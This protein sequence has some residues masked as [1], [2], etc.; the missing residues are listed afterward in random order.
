MHSCIYIC[1]FIHLSLCISTFNIHLH[2]YMPCLKHVHTHICMC[3]CVHT[4]THT[5]ILVKGHPD[6]ICTYLS[7]ESHQQEAAP[8]PSL[9]PKHRCRG[10]QKSPPSQGH[11]W[12]LPSLEEPHAFGFHFS[13]NGIINTQA[14][15]VALGY[16]IRARLTMLA[17][18]VVTTK[19]EVFSSSHHFCAVVFEK[20]MVSIAKHF[21]WL[22]AAIFC[23]LCSFFSYFSS[24]AYIFFKFFCT[25]KIFFMC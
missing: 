10:S 22:L 4:H 3:V 11:P 9:S 12:D 24:P 8:G 13:S 25:L 5:C 18:P 6:L 16:K 23:F 19:N 17:G 15:D 1:P 2:L 7:G 14:P 21:L 20:E